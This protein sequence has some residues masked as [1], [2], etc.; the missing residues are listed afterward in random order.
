L[1]RHESVDGYPFEIVL[2]FTNSHTGN[3]PSLT[4]R[5]EGFFGRFSCLARSPS[6]CE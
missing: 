5:F 1:K 4:S 3:D 6:V 2:H